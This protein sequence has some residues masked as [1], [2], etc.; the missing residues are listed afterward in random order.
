MIDEAAV[1]NT[2]VLS[3]PEAKQSLRVYNRTTE[4]FIGVEV[5]VFDTTA[6]P[7]RRLFECL[8]NESDLG[9]WLKPYK[10]VPAMQGART[11]DLVYLDSECRVAERLD[12]YP[13]PQVAI[14]KGEPTSALLLPAHG[15]FVSQIRTGD[16]LAICE[17]A[18]LEGML[19]A[20]S[21][22]TGGDSGT[23]VA[24]VVDH[25]SSNSDPI[26]ISKS[27]SIEQLNSNRPF[28][29]RVR[30]WFDSKTL[31]K[32]RSTRHPLPG[33]IAYHWSGGTPQPYA[34]GDLSETGFYLL[35]DERPYPGTLF[36][37]TLQR[38]SAS[39]ERLQDSVAVYT[40]VTRW[41]TD[42]VG[43]AFVPPK[44]KDARKADHHQG[45]WADQQTLNLFLKRAL[46]R[47]G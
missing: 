9:L 16:Q 43:F 33:L 25:P 34:L 23:Q 21:G 30:R 8:V 37:M 28:H 12:R 3:Q 39:G 26:R 11:F 40:K 41:G 24:E 5:S 22:L 20:L 44:V 27:S 13:N 19:A 4:S 10:G 36:M 18:E 1:T 17:I 15:A 35:T 46:V 6:E 38:T 14:L 42:G 2:E 31:T 29:E 32:Q 7:L 45:D 47:E